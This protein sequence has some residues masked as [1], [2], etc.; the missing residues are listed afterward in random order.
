[1]IQPTLGPLYLQPHMLYG[2]I[3]S[4]LLVAYFIRFNWPAFQ[5]EWQR[6]RYAVDFI[7]NHLLLSSLSQLMELYR[8]L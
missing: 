8:Y 2:S 5:T 3:R 4:T 6:T 1:M 7:L